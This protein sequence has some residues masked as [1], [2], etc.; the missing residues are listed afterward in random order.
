[1][2]ETSN[3]IVV[4]EGRSK[5]TDPVPILDLGAPVVNT[6]CQLWRPFVCQSELKKNHSTNS[7]QVFKGTSLA[8]VNLDDLTFAAKKIPTNEP[9]CYKLASCLL[10]QSAL[11]QISQMVDAT[12]ISPDRLITF[13]AREMVIYT[14]DYKQPHR[15]D[16]VDSN[17]GIV[18]VILN[19]DFTGGEL[20]VTCEDQVISLS[21]GP[22]SWVAVHADASCTISP[23]T[24]GARVSLIFDLLPAAEIGKPLLC[25]HGEVGVRFWDCVMNDI[26]FQDC[27]MDILSAVAEL[28]NPDMVGKSVQ[29]LDPYFLNER[30]V[31]KLATVPDLSRMF[32]HRTLRVLP[33]HVAIHKSTPSQAVSHNYSEERGEGYLG[34]LV[35]VLGSHFMSGKVMLSRGSESSTVPAKN[36]LWYA[37]AANSTH[38]LDSIFHGTR[39]SLEYDIFDAGSAGTEPKHDPLAAGNHDVATRAH[40]SDK[41]RADVQVA[42]KAELEQCDAL[43]LALQYLYPDEAELSVLEGGDRALYHTLM[44]SIEADSADGMFEVELVNATLQ[45]TFDSAQHKKV[46][47]SA[48]YSYFADHK[49]S[50]TDATTT[51]TTT[52]TNTTKLI[53]PIKLTEQHRAAAEG[54]GQYSL[55]ALRVRLRK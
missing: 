18:E 54:E 8:T 22:Y 27:H 34:T 1:M 40:A 51:T 24:S 36:C 39:V 13:K 2:E 11:Q 16:S 7:M 14:S 33:T 43:I 20:Q 4:H 31:A 10:S 32:P 28:L 50:N 25:L 30:T 38:I 26:K 42:L 48:T 52:T 44:E 37:Y 53:I 45:Y 5:L 3:W 29:Q 47:Q 35:V 21:T 55:S 23:V 6:L 46:L 17:V 41:V 15:H 49:N 12:R 9:G 19:S